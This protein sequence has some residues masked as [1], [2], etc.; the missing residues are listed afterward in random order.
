MQIVAEIC[1]NR[2]AGKDHFFRKSLVAQIEKCKTNESEIITWGM[3]TKKS[4]INTMNWDFAQIFTAK[5]RNLFRDSK[6][7]KSY[8]LPIRGYSWHKNEI[9]MI[10]RGHYS[11]KKFQ[12]SIKE[13]KY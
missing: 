2:T 3:C 6:F 8:L 13:K 4:H 12:D 5:S 7:P 1:Q 11:S 10:R 9:K